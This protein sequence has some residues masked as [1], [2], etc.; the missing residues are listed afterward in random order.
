MIT[1]HGFTKFWVPVSHFLNIGYGRRVRTI[2]G[3]K[4]GH[5]RGTREGR[6]IPLGARFLASVF[7]VAAA[8]AGP[9]GVFP[10]GRA[11]CGRGGRGPG[12]CG[13]GVCAAGAGW[14][15]SSGRVAEPRASTGVG[16]GW[17]G[18]LD[19]AGNNYRRR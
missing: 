18:G 5:I 1:I 7:F 17:R 13:V 15:P 3:F 8:G 10:S 11:R 16:R 4:T 12:R 19:P 9:G 2:E 6:R 14:G